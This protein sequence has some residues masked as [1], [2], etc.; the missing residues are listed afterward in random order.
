MT[1]EALATA[2]A[3]VIRRHWRDLNDH[4]GQPTKRMLDDLYDTAIAFAQ[5]GDRDRALAEELTRRNHAFDRLARE[6]NQL[7]DQLITGLAT[8]EHEKIAVAG[9]P[10]C[11]CGYSLND[12]TAPE[13]FIRHIVAV[14]TGG[15]V[16]LADTDTQPAP[17]AAPRRATR[18]TTPK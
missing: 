13:T 18:R 10:V 15:R 14:I 5:D 16:D 17:K 8:T 12:G 9:L 7:V 3:T 11:K 1:P 2:H 4:G 6:H